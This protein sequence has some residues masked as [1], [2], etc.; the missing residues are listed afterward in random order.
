[1][2]VLLQ[3]RPSPFIDGGLFSGVRWSIQGTMRKTAQTAQPRH[4]G[5]KMAGAAEPRSASTGNF[6]GPAPLSPTP[7]SQAWSG[8][9]QILPHHPRLA[10]VVCVSVY[11]SV[12]PLGL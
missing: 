1:M 5:L 11:V 3:L 9:Y 10:W 7:S 4:T 8:A 12:S 2:E 6:P